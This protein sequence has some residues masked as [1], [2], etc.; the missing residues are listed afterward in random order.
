MSNFSFFYVFVYS[1]ILLLSLKVLTIALGQVWRC[2][3]VGSAHVIAVPLGAHP[4]LLGSLF[5]AA[6][7]GLCGGRRP[8]CGD[9]C[10]L[11]HN[12]AEGPSRARVL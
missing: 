11:V 5:A 9:G 8:I 3:Q 6:G 4:A 2:V 1:F 12:A 10:V 7:W